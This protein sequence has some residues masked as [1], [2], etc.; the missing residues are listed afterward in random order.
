MFICCIIYMP[1]RGWY[2]LLPPHLHKDLIFTNAICPNH[3]P[4]S[5]LQLEEKKI[6]AEGVELGRQVWR[7]FLFRV[8]GLAMVVMANLI[9]SLVDQLTVLHFLQVHPSPAL[10]DRG[11]AV[12][13]LAP[14]L[15][16]EMVSGAGE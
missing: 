7:R 1:H 10:P 16:L 9:G 12:A 4:R 11:H 15:C 3:E 2:A 13:R 14:N 8:S 5:W 6:K